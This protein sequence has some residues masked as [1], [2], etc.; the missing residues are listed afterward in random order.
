MEQYYKVAQLQKLLGYFVLEVWVNFESYFTEFVD[1]FKG[2][3]QCI[4]GSILEIIVYSFVLLEP[5]PCLWD[6]GLKSP[7]YITC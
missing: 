5:L 7:L 2:D 3:K 6:Y 1:A 4:M